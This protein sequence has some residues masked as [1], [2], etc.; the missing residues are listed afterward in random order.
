MSLAQLESVEN[1]L[2]RLGKRL[3]QLPVN[4]SL[5]LR[6]AMI[7]GRDATALLDRL[8]KPAGLAEGEFRLLM[9][10]LA[11][12]GSASAGDLCAALAQSPANL[13]RIADSLV[14]R[15]YVSRD[16]DVTDRRRMLLAL[17][18]EGERLLNEM[19]PDVCRE[20]TALFAG[21]TATDR[22]QML[23]FFK[24]LLAGIDS[25]GVRDATGDEAR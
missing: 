18:P 6:A 13:T 10:L 25:L 23:A 16:P 22:K 11:H 17:L 19:L 1:N 21:F 20:V 9:S 8:L 2:R 15:G 7:L 24:R 4:E 12:G 14:E 3:P 5:I